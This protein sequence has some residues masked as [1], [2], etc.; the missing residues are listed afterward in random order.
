MKMKSFIIGSAL[1]F[2]ITGTA[3][4]GYQWSE[5]TNR[6][7]VQMSSNP[8][9]DVKIG[10]IALE[11]VHN[12]VNVTSKTYDISYPFEKGTLDKDAGFMD[13]IKHGISGKSMTFHVYASY[14]LKS[15]LKEV[16]RKDVTYDKETKTLSLN[17]AKP[18]LRVWLDK[19]NTKAD[20]FVSLFSSDFSEEERLRI[21]QQAED[22]GK[23][24]VEEDKEKMKQAEEDIKEGL[25][26]LLSSIE[27][28]EEVH[29]NFE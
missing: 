15:N 10:K 5:A 3:I 4:A 21:Y 23:M 16:S 24:K 19:K 25:G 1:V 12:E 29:I 22:V 7:T 14:E 26:G 17:L 6:T 18:E 11:K 28:I 20:S 8:E 27:G 13:K 2:T 9:D